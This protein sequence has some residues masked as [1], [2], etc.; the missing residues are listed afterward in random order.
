MFRKT[1]PGLRILGL[2]ST[3][4]RVALLLAALVS[5]AAGFDIAVPLITQRLI[6]A[7]VTYFKSPHGSVLP[8]LL[9]SAGSILAAT[10][11][12][13][14][15][16]S[17]YAYR[18]FRTCTQI[19]DEV[20]FRT[21][22]NYLRLHALYHYNAN[23]GQIIGRIESGCGAVFGILFDIM[24]Q[25]LIPPVVVFGGVLVALFSENA[26]IGITVLLPVPVYALVV[27]RLTGRIY[28][29]EQQGCEDFEAVSK[30]RYDVAGNVITVKKFSQERAEVRRQIALQDKA[31][32]TQF[33]GER[34]WVLVEN[35]QTLIATLGRVA[36]VVLSGWLVIAG[37]AT[38]GQFV[39]YISLAEMAYQPVSQL[40]VLFPRL[41]RS[42]A[43]ADRLFS[44]LDEKP[45][46][47]DRPD[48]RVL[49]PHHESIEFR[50][51]WFRYGECE[52]WTLRG[53]DLT[54]PCG[55]TVALVGR[56]GSGKTTL[57]NLLL[58]MFDPQRGGIFID[59]HDLRD[60]T[61]ESLRAQIA[62]VPQEVDLFSRTVAENIAYGRPGATLEQVK[63]AA[64]IA[65]AHEFILRT[66]N[67]YDTLVGERGLKLSGGERQRIGIARAVLRDPR[68]FVLDEA[69]SQL[70]TESEYKIQEAAERVAAGRT[71]FII[72]HRLSTVLHADMIV[73]FDRG[74][75]EAV[76]V[77][78]ELI[79]TSPTYRRLYSFFEAEPEADLV[80]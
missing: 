54:V 49:P 62:V 38:V 64:A 70:D 28:E 40:S 5:I 76:G 74:T 61:Q 15:V 50:D 9:I 31:R 51:V 12:G 78:A 66:E 55:A 11:A 45:A 3:R 35:S 27:R 80:V 47:T 77:H 67:G 4:K 10:A 69:T 29:I 19:E 48:A 57:A 13:R 58:R 8:M 1:D 72:A 68:I 46:V 6:D 75:I 24:G 32:E 16:R 44:V 7:L 14:G 36:V 30:E 34:L 18:L 63:E 59:G 73:V 52:D 79:E 23:S 41:R 56:S 65:Q 26:W 21:F 20:R 37:R 25:N 71:S 39:L 2:F 53:I 22:E 17:F 33:R 60:V 43:H 42:M